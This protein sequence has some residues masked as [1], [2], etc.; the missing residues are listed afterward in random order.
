[1]KIGVA[2]FAYNRSAKLK[3]VLDSL[4]KNKRPDKLYLFQD[5]LKGGTPV[6]EWEKTG[7]V[8]RSVDWC[9]KEIKI[10]AYNKGLSESI[11]EGINYVFLEN[12]AVIV[13]EDDC[14]PHED[15]VEFM[16]QCLEC[17][18]NEKKVWNVSGYAWPVDMEKPEGEDV[19]FCGRISSWGWGTWKD[20]FADY[21]R[22]YEF[23]RKICRMEEG[24]KNLELWGADL[25][26]Q[27]I[28]NVR[29]TADSW[30]VFWALKVIYEKGL[31]INPYGTLIHNIG[32]DGSGVHCKK[33][34]GES[35][36]FQP[37]WQCGK[38]VRFPNEVCIGEKTKEAFGRGMFRNVSSDRFRIYFD[39]M[40]DWMRFQRKGGNIAGR[41]VKSNLRNIA[42][43]GT[44]KLCDLLLEELDGQIPVSCIISSMKTDRKSVV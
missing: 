38:K 8:I 17:Y 33:R 28:G 35:G 3:K 5:G 31:C 16:T 10:S 42:V 24:K 2:V 44:G 43:Y 18:A 13:L 1:M 15:F 41:L 12:D 34:E 30:A 23:I 21:H 39:V 7:E 19:Y 32:F 25:E 14:V 6:G 37:E 29:G 22:D 9:Q 4:K 36:S 11:L 26:A 40:C 20:R 27:L